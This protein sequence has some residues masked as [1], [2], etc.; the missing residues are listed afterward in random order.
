LTGATPTG[1]GTGFLKMAAVSA[2]AVLFVTGAI[3]AAV[4]FVGLVFGANMLLS[5]R[6]PTPEKLEP[7]ECGMPPA[8]D[9][10]VRFPIRYAAVAVLF[11]I[12]DVEAVLLFAVASRIR[13]SVTGGLAVLAF[14][15]LLALGL[16]F[17]WKTGAL[18]WRS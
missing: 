16:T 7:Y 14:S 4:A 6:K 13:G 11:V 8:G 18:K 17:A 9:P 12:F 15:S 5:P 3:V 2:Q 1:G 10:H